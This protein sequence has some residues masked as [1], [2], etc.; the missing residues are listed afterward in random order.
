MT[1]LT[2]WTSPTASL[3]RTV[4][5]KVSHEDKDDDVLQTSSHM[6]NAVSLYR[7]SVSTHNKASDM[8]CY[9]ESQNNSHGPLH[10]VT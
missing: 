8:T 4:G 10:G 7:A 2:V 1:L 6:E 3:C 9:I 5:L